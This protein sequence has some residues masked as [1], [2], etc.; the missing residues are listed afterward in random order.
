MSSRRPSNIKNN[1][2]APLFNIEA[3]PTPIK[4]ML[5][6]MDTIAAMDISGASYGS[7]GTTSATSTTKAVFLTTIK[8]MQ[9]NLE[10]MVTNVE[11]VLQSTR[12][13][14]EQR[15]CV[16][17]RLCPPSIRNLPLLN[18]TML[19]KM[20]DYKNFLKRIAKEVEKEAAKIKAVEVVVAENKQ[21]VQGLLDQFMEESMTFE[22]IFAEYNERVS[23]MLN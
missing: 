12:P 10:S 4:P 7:H 21:T 6:L 5:T 23:P 8:A 14:L 16:P 17:R 18:A 20:E 3:K 15:P 19:E 22:A 2:P 1:N 11:E 13:I 9:A